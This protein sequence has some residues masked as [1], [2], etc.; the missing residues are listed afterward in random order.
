VP[1]Q[2]VGT[3]VTITETATH[4]GISAGATVIARHLKRPRLSVTMEPAHYA[5][6][7]RTAG[8]PA[9]FPPLD[10]PLHGGAG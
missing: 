3:V 6:L 10:H 1:V 9:R 7:L 5:G 4:Y 2:Y 8:A